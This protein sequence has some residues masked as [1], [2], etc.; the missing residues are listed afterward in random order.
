MF[1]VFNNWGHSCCPG[2][3]QGQH[4]YQSFCRKKKKYHIYAWEYRFS[5]PDFMELLKPGRESGVVFTLKYWRLRDWGIWFLIR[6]KERRNKEEGIEGERREERDVEA[7][8][9][10]SGEGGTETRRET[11]SLNSSESFTNMSVSWIRKLVCKF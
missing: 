6:E 11:N 4:F 1:W 5:T 9:E 10:G 2:K 7:F 3:D 8:V